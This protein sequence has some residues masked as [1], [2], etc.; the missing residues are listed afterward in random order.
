MNKKKTT[1]FIL[2]IL[3]VSLSFSLIVTATDTIKIGIYQNPPLVS[4]DEEGQASGFFVSLMNYVAE[5]ENL[6]IEYVYDTLENNFK[7]LEEGKIDILLAVAHSE[8]RAKKYIYNNETIYSNWG[9]IYSNIDLSINTFL[10]LEGRSIG[11][12]K[13]DIHYIGK[14][15]IK[16]SL[17]SFNISANFIE[18]PDRVE[19]LSDLENKKI[20]AAVVS[21]LF[22]EYYESNYNIKLTPI[23]FNPIKIKVIVA[24]PDNQ[25]ILDLFDKH[26][27][28]LRNNS[29]SIYYQALNNLL[30]ADAKLSLSENIKLIIYILASSLIAS[31]ITIL[32]GKKIIR[33]HE[34]KI[35]KQNQQLKKLVL[36][37]LE[38]SKINRIDELF[39]VFVNQLKDITESENVEVVSLIDFEDGIRLDS[40]EYITQH[41]QEY[42]LKSLDEVTLNYLN[43]YEL[44]KFIASDEKILFSNQ[45]AIAKYD[46]S[47]YRQGYLYIEIGKPIV[48]REFIQ[49]Y[50]VN[51][52]TTLQKNILSIKRINEKTKLFMSL[53]ELIEKRDNQVAN[54]V[55]RVSEATKILANACGYKEERLIDIV[56]AS[57]VHDIGKIF[58]PDH[59]LNKPGKLTDEEFEIIKSHA[60]DDL[61]MVDDV[62]E[63][64]SKT[65]HE[66]VRY[67]H[68]N[69]DG[70]GYPE[71]LSFN[72]IPL[73]AR[74]VSII[75]VFEALTHKRPYK[76]P[77]SYDEALNY[78]LENK[79]KN[80]IRKL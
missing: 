37:S 78:I 29:H 6:E 51:V 73:D 15:G 11:V 12:E 35:I 23:Q 9:Q 44:N 4:I 46:S 76:N 41:Y 49:V 67:H 53:G 45:Y 26:M 40:K 54:H 38:L 68:E 19:M 77:W 18:Y 20:D 52:I 63:T 7:K 39:Q 13:G 42:E 65:V 36:C 59:I 50:L 62:G 31:F 24:T 72:Q 22:G 70:S 10:D 34:N 64:L 25:Y 30:S 27:N 8:E 47:H 80:L 21:R 2:V 28:V 3:V 61:K 66:V 69:W 79:N 48:N 14:N 71:G 75:D 43:R 74:I 56:I 17:I 55:V 32:L 16:D 60:T 33:R 57:S 1:I 58:V 5:K